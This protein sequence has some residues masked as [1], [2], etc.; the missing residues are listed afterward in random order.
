MTAQP[1]AVRRKASRLSKRAL[2][3]SALGVVLIA[4]MALD[5]TVIRLD[6]EQAAQ[7]AGF[8]PQTFG[9]TEFPNVQSDIESRAVD[10]KTLADAVAAD[11][12]AATKQ[13][14]VGTGPNAVFPVKFTGI[15]GE[16]KSGIYP[17]TVEGLPE[18]LLVRVQTG[19][20][21]NGTELRDATGKYVFGQF[22]NQIEFQNAGSAL[23]NAMKEAV[24]AQVDAANLKGKTVSVTGAFKLIN[25]KSWLVTPVRL[26]VQP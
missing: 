25:P 23:N 24:L 26:E 1:V 20:A 3:L 21:I 5:T 18:G 11:K 4:A 8:S 12:A 7:T 16:P 15:A 14:A 2:I 9:Q 22:K 19:P 13:Y 6:S 10:A 17:I